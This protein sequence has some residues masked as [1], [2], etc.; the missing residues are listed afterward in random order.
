LNQT[1]RNA[2][3]TPRDMPLLAIWVSPTRA[4]DARLGQQRQRNWSQASFPVTSPSE[5][6]STR[7]NQTLKRDEIRSGGG[8]NRSALPL[9]LAAA[10][11]AKLALKAW[12]GR[13]ASAVDV[14]WQFP[15]PPRSIERVDPRV[16]PEGRLSSASGRGELNLRTDRF[17]Q[18]PACASA[19]L[20]MAACAYARTDWPSR[21]ARSAL[22]CPAARKIHARS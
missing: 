7:L 12:G 10:R 8:N 21:A 13:A 3:S 22:A 2:G 11:R 19:S 9:P 15:H 17:N 14:A 5:S 20:R 1:V 16:K 18:K 4:I 6:D